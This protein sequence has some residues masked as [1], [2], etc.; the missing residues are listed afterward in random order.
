MLSNPIF[1]ISFQRMLRG[2][3]SS[4]FMPSPRTKKNS[5]DFMKQLTTYWPLLL[6]SLLLCTPHWYRAIVK[7]RRRL[8]VLLA[9]VLVFWICVYR[10]VISA[11]N[12]FMYFS[13]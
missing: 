1:S 12:P 4:T 10:I 2:S 5:G 9:L 3:A 11:S 6:I 7:N 8:P 13:F